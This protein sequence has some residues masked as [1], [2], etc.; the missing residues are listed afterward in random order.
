MDEL[1]KETLIAWAEEYN[2]P[3]YF[4]EDPIAFPRKFVIA[5]NPLRGGALEEMTAAFAKAAASLP[6]PVTVFSELREF[7]NKVTTFDELASI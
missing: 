5:N 7:G 6:A 2:D 3:K 1:L 4:Q